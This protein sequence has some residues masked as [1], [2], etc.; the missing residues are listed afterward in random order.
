MRYIQHISVN[1]SY[2]LAAGVKWRP[3]TEKCGLLCVRYYT[4]TDT[5][6]NDYIYCA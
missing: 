6:R 1:D 4:L 3:I 2:Y 5:Q